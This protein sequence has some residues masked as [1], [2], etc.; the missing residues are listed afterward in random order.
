MRNKELVNGSK[1]HYS[2]LHQ[3]QQGAGDAGPGLMQVEG[4]DTYGM[5]A[6]GVVQ[7][8]GLGRR[9]VEEHTFEGFAGGGALVLEVGIELVEVRRDEALPVVAWA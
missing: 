6:E 3:A 9:R 4:D 5:P 1:I 2:S 8:D 7:V